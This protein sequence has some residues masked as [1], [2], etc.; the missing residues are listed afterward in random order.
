MEAGDPGLQP[1]PAARQRPVEVRLG[2]R[3][4]MEGSWPCFM[5]AP[6]LLPECSAGRDATYQPVGGAMNSQGRCYW[7]LE[8]APSRLHCPRQPTLKFD[9]AQ[10]FVS[11]MSLLGLPMRPT[12][13]RYRGQLVALRRY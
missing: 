9:D 4:K 13:A 6:G 8:Q 12:N 3:M 5:A 7:L 1:P 10:F 11:R 2:H